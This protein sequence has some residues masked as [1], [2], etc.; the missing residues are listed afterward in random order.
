M[1][2]SPSRLLRSESHT[3]TPDPNSIDCPLHGSVKGA[4]GASDRVPDDTLTQKSMLHHPREAD[5]AGRYASLDDHWAAHGSSLPAVLLASQAF[6][7]KWS[8]RQRELAESIP[9]CRLIETGSRS[10]NI[11]MR[12]RDRVI[13]AVTD[14][15]NSVTAAAMN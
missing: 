10:H 2:P 13:E 5:I 9:G 12:H 3:E 14:L 8:A 7:P 1:P 11:H 6:G 4:V 15:A